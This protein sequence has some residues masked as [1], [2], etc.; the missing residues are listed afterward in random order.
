MS[1]LDRLAPEGVPL[2]D[3]LLDQNPK[4]LREILGRLS[5]AE[6]LA[7][8]YEWR[9]WARDDQLPPPGAWLVWLIMSGRGW[10][11]TR[12]GAEWVRQR[13]AEGFERIALVGRT[14]ADYRDVMIE[15]ESGILASTPPDE[16]VVWEPSRRRITWLAFAGTSTYGPAYSG[17]SRR[18]IATC[19]SA[20]KPE[21]LRG[22]QHDSL[23]AE[24]LAAW[25]Y[26]ETW[27]MALFG[28]RLGPDP[29]AVV[30]TTPRP[31]RTLRDLVKD[32]DTVVTRGSTYANVDNLAEGFRRQVLA[33]Y[34]GT[35]LAAQEIYGQLLDEMPGALW[36]RAMIEY[37]RA[38]R[39]RFSKVVVGVDPAVTST[40]RAALTGIVVAAKTI[41]GFGLVLDD[42]SCRRK[43]GGWASEVLAAWEDWEAD[44]VVGETN[45]G[46]DLVEFVLRAVAG[47]GGEQVP[48]VKVTASRGKRARAE[49][50]SLLYERRRVRHSRPLVDLEDDLCSW[51]PDEGP[52]SDRVDA[53]VWALTRLGLDYVTTA[54]DLLPSVGRVGSSPLARRGAY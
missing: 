35:H 4:D 23:W 38:D 21:Q 31:V 9:F 29:R 46:G 10:G 52:G 51:I 2:G 43:P 22:P 45:N 11:K 14:P 19:Y 7:L 30:T 8:S 47:S 1:V 15:G 41:D 49:P 5:E 18:A 6:L 27:D 24:E 34:E 28:L 32:P 33:R 37:E 44:E 3:W 12:T 36:S 17:P 53:M 26:Q 48:Y 50:I 25:T 13:V 20:A 16:P 54:D 42:R 39:R 40:E